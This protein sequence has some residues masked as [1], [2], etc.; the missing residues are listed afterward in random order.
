MVYQVVGYYVTIGSMQVVG[1]FDVAARLCAGDGPIAALVGG[2]SCSI[3][4]LCITT[5][6]TFND[7]RNVNHLYTQPNGLVRHQIVLVL[8]RTHASYFSVFRS[9]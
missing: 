4:R 5:P 3:Y 9:V 1:F 8:R 2:S 7:Y 6:R